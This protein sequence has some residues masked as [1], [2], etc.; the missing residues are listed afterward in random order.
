LGIYD[1]SSYNDKKVV[2]VFVEFSTSKNGT[3][4]GY[5]LN[6]KFKTIYSHT[7][8][9]LFEDGDQATTSKGGL[10]RLYLLSKLKNI[11]QFG[12]QLEPIALEPNRG[13]AVNGV[14]AIQYGK[15]QLLVVERSLDRDTSL[16][17]KV[18][19]AI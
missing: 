12:Y 3:L 8:E 15:N 14:S 18:F 5:I 2:G 13:F 7:E 16:H 17:G 1:D 11:T 6:K 9:P 19:Y 10:I 4:E